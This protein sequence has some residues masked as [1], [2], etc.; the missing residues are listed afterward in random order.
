MG[1]GRASVLACPIPPFLFSPPWPRGFQSA[2]RVL[3]GTPQKPP[4]LLYAALLTWCTHVI[5]A[6]RQTDRR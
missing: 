6:T 1:S 5:S 3:G 2:N 4:F